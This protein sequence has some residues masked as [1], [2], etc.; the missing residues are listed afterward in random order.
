MNSSMH[1][2]QNILVQ[3]WKLYGWQN[4]TRQHYVTLPGSTASYGER[5]Q[6]CTFENHGNLHAYLTNWPLTSAVHSGEWLSKR[7]KTPRQPFSIKLCSNLLCACCLNKLPER[8]PTTA[9]LR[10]RGGRTRSRDTYNSLTFQD[11]K[12]WIQAKQTVL[13]TK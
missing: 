13:W 10:V 6:T 12:V 7:Y 3:L 8:S 1:Y 9:Q 2:W 11:H 4:G 5:T